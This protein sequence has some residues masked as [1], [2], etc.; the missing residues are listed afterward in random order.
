MS[1]TSQSIRPTETKVIFGVLSVMLLVCLFPPM[2]VFVAGSGYAT[3]HSFIQHRLV[4]L[5][6]QFESIAGSAISDTLRST[7]AVGRLMAYNGIIFVLG[8]LYVLYC[9]IT[10]KRKAPDPA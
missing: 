4:F 1:Y 3:S 7:V 10:D 9:R 2:E 5:P 8:G 6:A